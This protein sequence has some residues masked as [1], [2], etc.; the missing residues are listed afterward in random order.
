[1][2]FASSGGIGDIESDP[3]I[4]I[5]TYE[6]AIRQLDFYYGIVKRQLL[7]YQSPTTGLFPSSSSNETV[8]CARDSIYCA[9]AIWSMHQSYKR[10][11]DDRGRAYE[12]GQSAVKCM[13]GLLFCWLKQAEKVEKFKNNQSADHALHSVFHLHTGEAIYKD[14][15]YGHLQIDVPSLYLLF[16]VQM[17]SSGVQIIYTMDEVTFI[18]NLVY[19]VERAYRTPDYGIWERGN[20]YNNNTPE[21]HASGIGMAKA[22]LEAINGCNLFGDKGAAWSVIYADIDA[23]NRNRSIFE[24]LLPRE[25]S[26]KN[27]DSSL[28]PCISFP[29][30]ATHDGYL[31]A[32]TKNK[33]VRKLKGEYGFKRFLRDGYGTERENK[34]RKYYDQGE[35][36]NF[37][38]IEC[39]W[40][41]FFMYMIIDGIFKGSTDQVDT[42]QK[43]LHQRITRD[44]NGDVLVPK[45]YYVPKE[46]IEAEI[47]EPG[48]Q[49]K[50][51]SKEGQ[52]GCVFLWGQ[53]LYVISQLLVDGLL[54]INELDP[55]RRFLP[56][57]NRPRGIGG[58]YSA[59]QGT[60][61]DL[62][63]QVV[64][65][66]ESMRLQA[67]MATYGIQ[68][69]TP[70]EI[71]PVEIWPPSELVRVFEYLG[72]NK[73]VGM[74]G[75]PP[76]P[77]G[78]LGTSKV[79]RICGQTILCY[80]LIFQS[81]NF[82]LSHDLPLLLDDIMSELQF[83]GKYWRLYG[84]PTVCL[85]IREEHMRD[86][87]FKE[88]LDMLAMLKAG[89]CHGL[90][91]RVGRLQSLTDIKKAIAVNETRND[92]K[93]YIYK[94]T[95]EIV[96]VYKTVESNYG[97][98]RLL[99]ILNDREG[100]NFSFNGATVIEHLQALNR[101]SGL[102]RNWPVVRYCSSILKQVI[103]S[104]CPFITSL[105]V[106]GKQVTVG[107]C[108]HEEYLVDKPLTP[109]DIYQIIYKWVYP[110]NHVQAVLQQEIILYL[111]K[112]IA[113]HRNLFTGIIKIRVGWVIRAMELYSERCSCH[114]L[115]LEL[116]SPSE[117]RKLVTKV[118]SVND[119]E[120]NLSPLER[121]QIAGCLSRVP[122]DFYERIWHI[123]TKTPGGI[124]LAGCLLPQE[125]IMS[126]MT[127]QELNFSWLVETFLNRLQSPERRQL[128]V[129]MIMVVSTILQRNP[130]LVLNGE[131]D[132]D[133]LVEDAFQL[134]QKDSITNKK[135]GDWIQFYN[136]IP[137]VTIR[138]LARAAVNVIL[139]SIP[140]DESQE[141]C[142]VS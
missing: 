28:L 13:R 123:L 132:L 65:I 90:K 56:S 49:L 50:V 69:Q 38:N 84:R 139:S 37:E 118:M 3:G 106:N 128:V 33:M 98:S 130:E 95:W 51:P 34:N 60:A 58:R 47:Q 131:V 42:Y 63:V 12:L 119:S 40:P 124:R 135:V 48:S 86:T 81:S 117:V 134:F 25:S 89:R 72:L 114:C 6:D 136:T 107:V 96:D 45:Y 46:S 111:G 23:H 18:Q 112:L 108:G 97:R 140:S 142:N 5:A 57:F 125:R 121:R 2:S 1:M 39:E 73:K 26:S 92:F 29:C 78:A 101:H 87:N 71:E 4:K 70:H 61:S 59:F 99:G 54:T 138:Y 53:A 127:M 76:R 113:T 62:V 88:M 102:L 9:A 16:L 17:I 67:M 11:D 55:I 109:K 91:V 115:P 75:R 66:A 52:S 126:D 32:T 116:L 31:Y 20:K 82:Y 79:Y 41:L 104:I 64:L 22:A 43:L 21:L 68:T 7:L 8:A 30:F 15:E 129:E 44:N 14:D 137:T 36:K 83:V 100:P 94:T 27:T 85:L 77:I 133:R 24:T 80:P 141:F 74:S 93:E 122:E 110:L 35:T 105:L 120:E 10:I 19:Y 103:D